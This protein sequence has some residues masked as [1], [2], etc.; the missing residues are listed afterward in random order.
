MP[1]AE[2]W[3]EAW[4]SCSGSFLASAC[5]CGRPQ[6][7]QQAPT[8]TAA[9]RA[10]GLIQ[11][12]R[13]RLTTAISNRIQTSAATQRVRETCTV[14][15][16]ADWTDAGATSPARSMTFSVLGLLLVPQRAAAT[17]MPYTMYIVKVQ[18]P[19]ITTSTLAQLVK[20]AAIRA[21][22][23][24]ALAG[25]RWMLTRASH[26]EK[27]NCP[28]RAMAHTMRVRVVT[29]ASAQAKMEIKTSSMAASVT[30]GGK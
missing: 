4:E 22:V 18:I 13:G 2:P 29:F 28:S 19:V 8:P 30:Y 3:T 17:T 10:I 14:P 11:A 23:Q 15:R 27:G 9:A 1:S 6:K 5:L 20:A 12:E 25:T 16:P 21:T 24:I 7:Y 26:A